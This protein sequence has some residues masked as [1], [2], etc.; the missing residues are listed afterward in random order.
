MSKQTVIV[1]VLVILLLVAV[2]Y[3]GFIYYQA[4]KINAQ[5]ALVQQGGQLGY[6]QAV[7]DIATLAAQCQTVPLQVGNQT[8]NMIAVECL[9]TAAAQQQTQAQ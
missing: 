5:N 3:I 6:Q 7:V 9:Q 4:A 2:G 1:I 8:I